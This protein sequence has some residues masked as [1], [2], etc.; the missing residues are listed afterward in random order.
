MRKKYSPGAPYVIEHA[1][2]YS[3]RRAAEH[4]GN[5]LPADFRMLEAPTGSVYASA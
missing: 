4:D 3:F 1:N 2:Q 5:V